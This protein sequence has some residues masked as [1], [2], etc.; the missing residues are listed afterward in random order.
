MSS[1]LKLVKER[2]KSETPVFFQGIKKIMKKMIIASAGLG[3]II[4]QTESASPDFFPDI[5][6]SAA[7]WISTVGVI[8][9]FFGFGVA[10]LPTTDVDLANKT[11]DDPK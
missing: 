6:V 9:G 4:Y 8:G 10:S 3:L 2:L 11:V 7:Q 1:F 5:I